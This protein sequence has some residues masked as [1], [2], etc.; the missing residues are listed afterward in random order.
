MGAFTL[1]LLHGFMGRGDDWK[2]VI[3]HLP[4]GVQ[5]IAPDL[6]GHG[7]TPLL[8]METPH[9]FEAYCEEV[10]TRLDDQLPERFA[11]SGYSMGGRI[12]AWLAARHPSR[13][14][15]LIL[16]G[17]HPGLA[18]AAERQA[19]LDHDEAWAQRFEQGPWPEVLDAWYR[20]PVFAS[21]DD[22]RRQAFIAARAPQEPQQLAR[23]LCA[24]SLGHQPSLIPGVAELDI[25]RTFIAGGQDKKFSVLGAHWSKGCPGL[26]LVKLDGLGHNCHAEAPE[27]VA[28]II[29]RTCCGQQTVTKSIDSP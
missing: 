13:V 21:L 7:D 18:E 1:V 23:A 29:H 28:H 3:G 24:A 9:P 10:W 8:T 4:A 12:A 20:Q 16:E 2:A 6:P 26:E 17:A 5:C 19:R 27:T 25:P 11:L 14:T 22:A 15:A